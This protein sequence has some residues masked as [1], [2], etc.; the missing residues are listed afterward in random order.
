MK[1]TTLTIN[2]NAVK[3]VNGDF[4]IYNRE[5]L[6]QNLATEIKAITGNQNAGM[7]KHG[8]WIRKVDFGNCAYYVCSECR[9]K[10]TYEYDFCPDC[11]ADMRG[12]EKCYLETK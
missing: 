1:T 5:W 12:E 6:K 10:E 4:V 7:V 8:H 11:G 3:V 9:N 2:K